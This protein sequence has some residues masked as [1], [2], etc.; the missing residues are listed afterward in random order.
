M[1][2]NEPTPVTW[3]CAVLFGFILIYAFAEPLFAH[4]LR[5]GQ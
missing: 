3:I 1:R 5:H 2:S 4:L